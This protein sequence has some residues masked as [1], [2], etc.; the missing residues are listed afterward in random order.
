MK[1]S[2]GR[3]ARAIIGDLHTLTKAMV[4]RLDDPDY[5]VESVEKREAL[6]EEFD[7]CI[8][9]H[10]DVDKSAFARQISEILAMDERINAS[11]KYLK[12][13]TKSKL[14]ETKRRQQAAAY[15]AT[16]RHSS[17]TFMNYAK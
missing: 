2:G 13:A 17:G 7:A 3:S 5:L 10:P 4:G 12:N 6:M 8:M 11:L 15:T 1:A 9:A 14:N 16:Q